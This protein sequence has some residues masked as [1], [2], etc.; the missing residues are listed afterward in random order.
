MIK[1]S[2]DKAEDNGLCT[3]HLLP[4]ADLDQLIHVFQRKRFRDRIAIFHYGG[5]AENNELL[6]ADSKSGLTG[7]K[8][9]GLIPFLAEQKGLKL[10]FL[11]G[12]FS[13]QQAQALIAAGIPAVI[14]TIAAVS[15]HI[16]TELSG[17]FYRA[18]VEGATLD[19]AW[20]EATY[21]VQAQWGDD[22]L[23]LLYRDSRGIGLDKEVARFPWEIHFRKG[24]ENIRN[25]NLP[26]AA[27][28]PYFGLPEIPADCGYPKEPYQFL[29]RYTRADARVFFGRGVY[30][31]DLY[32]RLQSPHTAPI[33]LLSGQSG[34]GKS[35]L[36]EAGL[37]PRLETTFNIVHLRYDPLRSLVEQVENAIHLPIEPD[38]KNSSDSNIQLILNYLRKMR[39]QLTGTAGDH[40]DQVIA[41]L[42]R[43]STERFP[44]TIHEQKQEK[45]KLV[46]IDQ[47][48]EIYTQSDTDPKQELSF[49]LSRL[50]QI[51]DKE[52]LVATKFIFSYRK[53]Y[54]Q[55]IEKA[56]RV[57][58][59]VYEK[60]FLDKLG[61]QGIEE[62]VKGLTSLPILWNKYRLQVEEGLASHIA[63]NLLAD[64][65]SPISPVL[66]I[67][68]TKMW[69]QQK[70]E[71]YRQFQLDNYQ[72]LRKNGI[73][74][75]DFF[76]EQM[77]KVKIWEA[78]IG[79]QI[80][81]SGLALD[82]LH[83]HTT[84]YQTAGARS[85]DELRKQYEHCNEILEKMIAKF[86]QLYLLASSGSKRTV[87]A[88]DTLAPIILDEVHRSGKPGQRALRILTTKMID[89][90][91]NPEQTLIDEDDLTLVE[92][93]VGGMRIW[94]AKEGELVQKSRDRRA[95][96]QAER[97]RHK[98]IRVVGVIVISFL[99]VMVTFLWQRSTREAKVNRLVSL[100][101]QLEKMDATA[102][103]SLLEEALLIL[104]ENHIAL[105]ARHDIYL[106][107]E[108]YHQTFHNDNGAPVHWAVWGPGDSLFITGQEQSI[109]WWASDGIVKDSLQLGVSTSCAF[110]SR[111]GNYLVIGGNDGQLRLMH[112]PGREVEI[113]KHH[114]Y[115]ISAIAASPDG[116][117]ILSGD[118]SGSL[119]LWDRFRENLFSSIPG[120]VNEIT[121]LSFS[122][123]GQFFACGDAKGQLVLYDTSGTKLWTRQHSAK[124]SS[125]HFS[126]DGNS[127][128][129]GLRNGKLVKWLISGEPVGLFSGHQKRINSINFSPNRT[130]F[131]TASDDRTVALWDTS[132]KLLKTYRGHKDFAYTVQFSEDGRSFVSASNDGS[133]KWWKINSKVS[134]ESL[135]WSGSI[136]AL[137]VSAKTEMLMI[138][139]GTS[140]SQDINQL[141]FN[142]DNF[143]DQ[144][145]STDR[146]AF[147]LEPD[148]QKQQKLIGHQ[149]NIRTVTLH[150]KVNRL[151]SGGDDGKII[152][153]DP[154]GKALKILTAHRGYIFALTYSPEGRY[155]ASGSVDST[156]ILWSAG[157]DSLIT[158]NHSHA[159][160]GVAFLATEQEVITTSYDGYVRRWSMDG[161]LKQAWIAGEGPITVLELSPDGKRLA[162]GH[163]GASDF[164]KIWNLNGQLLMMAELSVDNNTGGKGVRALAFTPDGRRIIAGGEGGILKVF[165]QYGRPIQTNDNFSG[166]VIY[167]LIAI[168]NHEV[169]SASG[170]G[171]LRIFPLLQ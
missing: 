3:L 5:H 80:E 18:L 162:T 160:S 121:G 93:G 159:V 43:V 4:N 44:E 113:R 65:N 76:R 34:V 165:D 26:D 84:E 116:R 158:L 167:G 130:H 169:I 100:A 110:F 148:W 102:A 83:Y 73:L 56:F 106:N 77:Q 22:Q 10:V 164:L 94:T 119:S 37:F 12:C 154:N 134:R 105:Q 126:P 67:I 57:H 142:N 136:M 53:E 138:G 52:E 128:F 13:I 48:E 85:L 153:W 101:F 125:L 149:G 8:A 14:G 122:P 170:D 1:E 147:L 60:I 24:H 39:S 79:Y 78:K 6:L 30:V 61:K 140:E 109:K 87:L 166:A 99:L 81:S 31:R 108:F 33:I 16:A 139:L 151:A 95:Q 55:E 62:V 75:E 129:V 71:G 20:K 86:E 137:D 96:L 88:H 40:L 152:I 19:Q 27:E 112:R 111:M 69:Q 98:N 17:S 114:S 90:K 68:L 70:S 82:I 143:F 92:K 15:D 32:H 64:K 97:R 135:R 171:H 28:D 59:L 7:A 47:L 150:P 63:K 41:Q 156:A 29:N 115:P 91:R 124:I 161:Q 72:E 146:S 133:V 104:P 123:D 50:Y 42:M 2:L 23:A 38:S 51:I 168:Q 9:E 118:L 89:Y 35:S 107:N 11:N 103:L 66:Q 157:G 54:D 25:W 74:L 46:V 58:H 49:L 163:G 132:G 144:F 131:L 117:M 155:L 145:E 120:Q 21:H 127:I 141:N 36:L 45:N